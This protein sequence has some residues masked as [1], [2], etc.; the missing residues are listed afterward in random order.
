MDFDVRL[1]K[2]LTTSSWSFIINMGLS[3]ESVLM[4]F[5]TLFQK[6]GSQYGAIVR[7]GPKISE[8]HGSVTQRTRISSQH[9]VKNTHGS[10]VYCHRDSRP[11]RCVTRN[12]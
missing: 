10:A 8:L 4:S 3:F 7:G 2:N 11:S 5:H 9:P 6:L 12:L 1:W